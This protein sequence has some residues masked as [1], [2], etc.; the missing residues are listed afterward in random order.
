MSNVIL[1][2]R[3]QNIHERLVNDH[4]YF[5]RHIQRIEPKDLL[6]TD[7]EV[8]AAV[9]A[10]TNDVDDE[11]SLQG[12][13]P[14]IFHP[15]QHKLGLFVSEQMAVHGFCYAA[16]V[17]P[18]QVGWSTFIHSLAHWLATKTPGMKI[19]TVAHNSESTRKFLRRFRKMCA[20]AP[21]MVTPGRQVENSK[22]I[23]FANGASNT[24]ATAGSP[25]A[26]RS[27]NCQFLHVSEESSF[28]DPIA[29]MAAL[30]PALSRGQ[31]AYGFR[32]SSSKGKFT[33]WHNFILEALAGENTWNVFFDA[34][35]N[36]PKNRMRPP[37][38][39]E[40]NDEA[41]EA[42][43][44]YGLSL[45][46]LY[47]RAMMIKDLRAL[48]LFKQEYPGTIHESFQASASTLYSPDAIY[49][50]S[51]NHGQIKLDTY[52]PLIMGVDP[53]RTG[54]R[55]AIAFRQG[56]VFRE[57]L[58]YAKMDDMRLVGIIAKYLKDGYKGTKIAKCFIDYAIGEGPASRLRELD[59]R[60]EVMTI[61]FGG[62]ANEE[63]F[64]NKRAEMAIS[65]FS[66]WLGDG[67]EVSIPDSDDITADLLAIPDFVQS[68]G[69]E[70]IKLPPKDLIKK[71]FGRSPDIADAMWL[72]FAMPVKG[73]RIAEL[74]EFTK[75]NLSHLRP[76]ELSAVLDDFERS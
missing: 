8:R 62:T 37:D 36:H 54:D 13:I 25:D 42:Q 69:S 59:F 10:L 64:A 52:A 41:R 4:E 65:G 24:I 49:K 14:L 48:W 51:K 53:A 75:T 11:T 61:H 73:E 43:L 34:W 27:D 56:R 2:P 47:W 1:S 9:E 15:G 60:E 74:H 40:P 30:L 22:E 66:D 20:A 45:D 38:G 70:K 5:A 19:H 28:V 39:W 18:R 58:V 67:S 71:E 29:L 68:T 3:D 50:A 17:K 35:F 33:H 32:E 57:V 21:D 44:L 26:L 6:E 16:L 46:Q 7:P 63:R 72:T 76:N 55:T 31:G 23:I 12:M